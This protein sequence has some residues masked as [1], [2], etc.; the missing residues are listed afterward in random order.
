MNELAS[1]QCN[2]CDN[3][4]TLTH[5]ECSQCSAKI[6]GNYQLPRLAR[7]P[8][9]QRDFVELFMLTGGNIR[10]M[11]KALGVSYPTIKNQLDK[12]TS[13]LRNQI[14]NDSSGDKSNQPLFEYLDE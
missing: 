13:T 5:F 3:D 11:E 14:I 6:T 2:Q 8:K 1:C 9:T 10:K 7:L 12:I 4:Y